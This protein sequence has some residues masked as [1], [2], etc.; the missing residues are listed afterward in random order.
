[1]LAVHFYS[2]EGDDLDADGGDIEVGS[3]GLVRVSDKLAWV[4]DLPAPMDIRDPV[5][6]PTRPS[7]GF[8]KVAEEP[9]SE[10]WRPVGTFDAAVW[11]DKVRYHFR[12]PYLRPGEVE[13]S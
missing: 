1:M 4:L 3:D 8:V 6:L 12:T 2:V 11:I 13:Q 5:S 7:E 9:G 10:V